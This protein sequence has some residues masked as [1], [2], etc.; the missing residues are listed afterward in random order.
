MWQDPIVDEIHRIRQEILAEYDGDLG[1]M[2][3][4]LR[5]RMARG[6]FG[7]RIVR[8]PPRPAQFEPVRGTGT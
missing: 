3:H 5:D 8:H 1:A 4:D 6:E 2:M 7:D